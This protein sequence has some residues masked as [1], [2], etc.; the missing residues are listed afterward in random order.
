MLFITNAF[1]CSAN[2][3]TPL[4]VGIASMIT[5][6][7]TV[8]YYQDIVDY[9]GQKLGIPVT[10]IHKRTYSEMDS[11][12]ATG[13]VDIAFICSAPYVKNRREMGVE[14]L[15][16]PQVNG[17]TSYRS[18]IIVHKD[19]PY[20]SIEDLHGSSFA[21][22]DPRSNTGWLYPV[23]ALALKG[24]SAEEF[25]DRTTYSHSHNKSVELVAKRSVDAAAIESLVYE[26]MVK[27]GS[28]YATQ[29]RVIAKSE[30]FGIPPVVSAKGVPPEVS[31]KVKSILLLMHSDEK[32]R[33]ILGRMSIERFVEVP[34]SNYDNIRNMEGFVATF[35]AGDKRPVANGGVKKTVRFGIIPRDNP[36][37][38]FEKYQVLMDY[39]SEATASEFELVLGK[40]YED[41]VEALGRGDVD[42]ALLGPLTYLEAYNRHGAVSTLKSLTE[43]GKP[44]YAGVIVVRADSPIRDIRDLKGR[45]VAFAA[46]K[47]TSGNRFARYMLAEA[48]IHLKDL[49][50]YKNFSFHDSVIRRVLAGEFDA[51][52]VRDSRVERYVPDKLRVI[53]TSGPIPTGPL[54][55]GPRTSYKVVESVRS[56]LLNL[57]KS[58]KG[59]AVLAKL[60]PEL[61]GGFVATSD[62]DYEGVRKMINEVPN[63]CG[64]SC[65]PRIRL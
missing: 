1:A 44:F 48:G 2:A 17:K 54:V 23:Y 41:T 49:S 55:A 63:T 58:E 25:F 18:Y 51:G 61:R 14:L 46:H 65:H 34:D 40:T 64:I 59:K 11:L 35:L 15:V 56:A 12:I 9:I 33:A 29:T 27:G 32:G 60:D 62:A 21:F 28:S 31:S 43:S 13:N 19:S 57:G 7:D 8:K 26:F 16:A 24:I 42:M 36:R 22:T 45:S 38:A 5:P 4:R 6:V 3:A 50:K 39:L 10:M 20:K 37:I 47:S 30:E 52:A 53:A